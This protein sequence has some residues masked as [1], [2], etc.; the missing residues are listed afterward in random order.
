M[1]FIFLILFFI[2]LY[3]NYNLN[4]K[5]IDS[6]SNE[7]KETCLLYN[8]KINHGGIGDFLKF[9]KISYFF[10]LKN[11]IKYFFINLEHPKNKFIII[12]NKFILKDYNNFKVIN[13]NPIDFY[14]T[15]EHNF[16]YDINFNI[17]NFLDFSDEIKKTSSELLQKKNIYTKFDGI[18]LRIGDKHFKENIGNNQDNRIGSLTNNNIIDKIKN[19]LLNNKNNLFIFFTENENFKSEIK[20]RNF[21][22]LKMFD[23]PIIHTGVHVKDYDK[24]LKLNLCEFYILTMCKEIHAISKSGYSLT[25]CYFNNSKLIKYY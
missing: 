2:I 14:K 4:N 3:L 10:S 5:I 22:N 9:L 12:N 1:Y 6:F 17:N 13:K 7:N 11:N 8:F 18:H 15:E 19:I 25:A 24:N 16:N 21:K 20:E 23:F